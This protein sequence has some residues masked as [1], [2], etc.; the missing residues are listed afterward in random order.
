MVGERLKDFNLPDELPVDRFYVKTP[1]FPFA[2]FQGVDPILGPEMK[3]TGEVMGIAEGFG[4]AFLKAMA[5]A[6]TTL[7]KGGTAFLSVNDHDK[8]QLPALAQRLVELGFKVIGTRG[9]VRTL[10]REEIPAEMVFKVNEGRP[11]VVDL[12]KSGKIHLIINTPL[13]RASFYDEQSI[14]RA[15]MQYS[16]PS[17][18]TLTGAN[19]AAKAIEAMQKETLEVRSLQEYHQRKNDNLSAAIEL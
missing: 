18:T 12:I 19:A 4:A 3:S 10:K 7:P 8:A 14:R 11:N 6:G 1:V 5:G 13:G 2:K 17:I 9:T 15:A 16:V